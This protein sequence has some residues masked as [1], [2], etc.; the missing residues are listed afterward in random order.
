MNLLSQAVHE[1]FFSLECIFRWVCKL[2]LVLNSFGQQ[3][4]GQGKALSEECVSRCCLKFA[5]NGNFS[6][7]P[8]MVHL[9][10]HSMC[11]RR[12]WKCRELDCV[13]L[14][15]D[16][17]NIGL[18]QAGVSGVFPGFIQKMKGLVAG[19]ESCCVR[20]QHLL[21]SLGDGL[22]IQGAVLAQC[23]GERLVCV[24][25]WIASMS[26]AITCRWS[27]LS[28]IVQICKGAGF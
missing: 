26:C 20:W 11:Q 28:C 9:N 4:C 8:G 22:A 18:L 14:V 5:G 19:E 27:R 16:A 24:C 12:T 3:G 25:C 10:R 13:C 2:Y 15:A 1:C 6:L 23:C 17:A 7:Q 21:F